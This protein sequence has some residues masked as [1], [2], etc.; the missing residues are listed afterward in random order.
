[1]LSDSAQRHLRNA[2]GGQLELAGALQDG[3][4]DSSAAQPPSPQVTAADAGRG[5]RDGGVQPTGGH[6]AARIC[7]KH[8]ATPGKTPDLSVVMKGGLCS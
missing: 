7:V 6:I 5:Q 1:M 3:G 2:P 4:T 8:L